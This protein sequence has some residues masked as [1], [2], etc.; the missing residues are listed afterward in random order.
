[1]NTVIRHRIPTRELTFY[2]LSDVACRFQLLPNLL[3]TGHLLFTPDQYKWLSVG[4]PLFLHGW[5]IHWDGDE[6]TC[7]D[8]DPCHYD[9]DCAMCGLIAENVHAQTKEL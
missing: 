2:K 4:S 1:M 8:G 7:Y 9:Y 3:S 6:N 5:E